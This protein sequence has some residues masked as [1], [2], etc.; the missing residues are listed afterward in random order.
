MEIGGGPQPLV[1]IN[2]S[3][4]THVMLHDDLVDG[5]V[6]KW[7]EYINNKLLQSL[8]TFPRPGIE[9][10]HQGYSLPDDAMPKISTDDQESSP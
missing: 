9:K 6:G 10:C 3:L 7:M 5:L 4:T 2:H 1:Y 8:L